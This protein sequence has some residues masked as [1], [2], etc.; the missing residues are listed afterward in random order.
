M[1]TL[2]LYTEQ[3]TEE[4][5]ETNEAIKNAREAQ[6]KDEANEKHY[7]DLVA[8]IKEDAVKVIV[9][10]TGE[11]LDFEFEPSEKVR[12]HEEAEQKRKEAER[13]R[14]TPKYKKS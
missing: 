5:K 12:K 7:D 14:K 10:M 6:S 9:K 13:K 11:M 3:I 2:K 4:I 8:K 1:L